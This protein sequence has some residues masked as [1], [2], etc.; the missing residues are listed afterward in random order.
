MIDA[1][2]MLATLSWLG[3]SQTTMSESC[4][5][6]FGSSLRTTQSCREGIAGLPVEKIV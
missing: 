2:E 1:T 5:N 4:T 6:T 3:T